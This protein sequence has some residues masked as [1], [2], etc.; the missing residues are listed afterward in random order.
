MAFLRF[1]N[2]GIT[3]MAGAVPANV[4]DN[5]KYTA[6]FPEEAVREIVDKVG[7]KQRRFV[8]EKTCSSD[9]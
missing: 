9:L 3:G 7:I 1:N 8:D 4:I 6:F 2:V 5:Y